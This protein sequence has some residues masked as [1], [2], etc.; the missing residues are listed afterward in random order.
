MLTELLLLGLGQFLS[1]LRI[2]RHR[3]PVAR[4]LPLFIERP[5]LDG[6]PSPRIV[7]LEVPGHHPPRRPA[8]LS[9]LEW[10]LRCGG[11]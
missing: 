10:F 3:L 1:T 6:E 4:R 5:H 9:W 11:R 2:E 8:R 7:E